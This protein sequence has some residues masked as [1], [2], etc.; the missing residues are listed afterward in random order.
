VELKRISGKYYLR[1]RVSGSRLTER[2]REGLEESRVQAFDGQ[3]EGKSTTS[4][5]D[6]LLIAA[7]RR[8]KTGE[9]EEK[10]DQKKRKGIKVGRAVLLCVN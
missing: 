9:K 1:W 10:G 7:P 5:K 6:H 4:G 2:P 8:K 3:M